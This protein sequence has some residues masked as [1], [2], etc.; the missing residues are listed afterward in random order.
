VLW[1]E[2]L[3]RSDGRLPFRG[4]HR[5]EPIDQAR[6]RGRC[7]AVPAAEAFRGEAGDVREK[8]GRNIDRACAGPAQGAHD[9]YD[10][11][12]PRRD[13][14]VDHTADQ[15]HR[16]GDAKLAED[17]ERRG[18]VVAVPVVESEEHAVAVE[19]Q[20]SIEVPLVFREGE[21][22]IVATAHV[23]EVASEGG[24]RDRDATVPNRLRYHTVVVQ[25]GASRPGSPPV[26]EV[27]EEPEPSRVVHREREDSRDSPTGA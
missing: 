23:L 7:R 1:C 22:A 4:R 25:H 18:V 8:V 11:I 13:T 26:V 16:R 19:R 3:E 17:R 12:P 5:L 21:E 20:V 2:G 14:G 10:A 9:G 15:E 6:D 24:R 27:L